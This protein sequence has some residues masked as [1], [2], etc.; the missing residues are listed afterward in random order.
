MNFTFHLIYGC[1]NII[2]RNQIR[3]VV[4]SIFLIVMIQA[5]NYYD[6]RMK[7]IFLE[8][9][10]LRKIMTTVYLTSTYESFLVKI[11]LVIFFIRLK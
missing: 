11:E 3:V 4:A 7:I 10:F 6:S 8:F 5:S 2:I 1:Q 9:N